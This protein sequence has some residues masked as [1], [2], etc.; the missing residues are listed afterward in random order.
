MTRHDER[1]DAG[2]AAD[3]PDTADDDGYL[4]DIPAEVRAAVGGY[5][6]DTAGG[7]G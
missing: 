5:D 4:A 3:Q 2:A 1:T 7:C 6:T